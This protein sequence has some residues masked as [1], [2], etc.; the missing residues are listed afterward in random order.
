MYLSGQYFR[1]TSSRSEGLAC[2]SSEYSDDE[3]AKPSLRE[4]V[5]RKYWPER[6]KFLPFGDPFVQKWKLRARRARAKT[7]SFF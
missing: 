3:H 2:S 7:R 6:Y 5:E 4:E 1:S